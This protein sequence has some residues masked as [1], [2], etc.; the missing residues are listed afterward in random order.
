MTDGIGREFI[1]RTKYEYLGPSDQRQGL[2]QPPL[3][4]PVEAGTETLPL[5]APTELDIPSADLRQAIERR[6]SVRRY[7]PDPLSLDEL[8]FFLWTTQGVKEVSGRPVTLRTVPSAGARHAFE[9]YL[10]INRVTGVEP[11]LYRYLALEHALLPQSHPADIA[12][13]LTDACWQQ[14]MVRTSAV[15]FFWAAVT[16]R[17]AWR[18]GERGYRYLFLDAGHVCQNL[19]LAAEA[20][21]CGVCAIAAFDDDA[22]NQTLGIDGDAQFVVYV[23]SAGKKTPA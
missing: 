15:T 8:S 18:Y 7:A 1:Q 5:P 19:Y 6:V 12:D 22:L 20:V 4:I 14:K 10:L 16:Y 13:R 23:A 2:P 9:T 17:M 11:G 3:Q 21:N